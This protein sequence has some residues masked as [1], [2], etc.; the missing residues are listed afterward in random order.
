MFKKINIVPRWI[1]F[2][3]DNAICA[4]AML[5]AHLIRYNLAIEAIDVQILSGNILILTLINSIVFI[6]FRTYAGIIRYTGIQDA[7]RICYAILMTTSVLF[8]IGLVSSNAGGGALNF[9]TVTLIIYSLFSFLFLISYRVIVKYA[10]AYLRNYKMDRKNVIIYGAGEAGF[11]TKRVLEHD[12]TSNISVVAFI[13]DDVRKVGKVVDGVKIQHRLDLQNISLSQ[14]IDE[15]IIA[16]F[17]MAP[18]KKNELVDFCLDHDI[19]VLN[20]PPLDKW[21]NGE[22]SARQLQTIKIENLLE[23]EPIRINNEEIASQVKGKRVLVTGAAGSIG[24]EI[25]RQL[26][27]FQPHTIIL[28][29]QAETPLH[30]LELELQELNPSTACIPYLGD[31]T[32]EERM[33]EMFAMYE[34]HYVYHAAAY[35]HV[36]MMEL[37]PSEAILTNVMGTK[38]IADLS[39]KHHVHRFVMVSTDKAVNPTNVMGASKRLAECYV[40]SLYHSAANTGDKDKFTKFITT[41][42]GNVL[43]SNGSVII[44]FKEQIEKGGPVTVTHPNI[45]R[46]FMTIPEACQLVLEAGSMGSGGEIFVF[47]MGKP[48]PIV[49]LAKKMIRLYGYV[50]G[51][52]IEIKYSGLRPGEKLYEELLMDSENTLPTYHEKIMIAKVRNIQFDSMHQEFTS[53]IQLAK[54]RKGTMEMVAKMKKLVPEFISNNSVFEQLDNGNNAEVIAMKIS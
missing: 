36:P 45:T 28:C 44:R 23:R 51:I 49:D 43:G 38:I 18:D 21:I 7:L 9:A 42:F 20:V 15:I 6:N 32:N 10:F 22:F 47:D 24:S 52:D 31:V 54:Q 27:R 11:A 40:Q 41:R 19:K 14:K 26:L 30:H 34:P 53:L 4:F 16:A 33:Q 25:V 13:D 12:A 5:F 35:K 48:V 37:C 1:I 39:V 50:P 8:F 2:L 46:F 29:D 17:N 3:I